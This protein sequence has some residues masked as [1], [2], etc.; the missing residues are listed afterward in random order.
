M[1]LYTTISLFNCVSASFLVFQFLKLF[2]IRVLPHYV[3]SFSSQSSTNFNARRSVEILVQISNLTNPS[4]LQW[5]SSLRRIWQYDGPVH[6]RMRE[7][8]FYYLRRFWDEAVSGRTLHFA[9]RSVSCPGS[10]KCLIGDSIPTI[11][12]TADVPSYTRSHLLTFA[13][14]SNGNGIRVT[15]KRAPWLARLAK[16]TNCRVEFV[17]E[18]NSL[19]F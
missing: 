18:R 5:H 10:A 16:P 8:N 17:N 6:R 12:R 15:A 9:M 13:F 14:T 7:S 1:A 11:S 2:P 4:V 19:P 3:I